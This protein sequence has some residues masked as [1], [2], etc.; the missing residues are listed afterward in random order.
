M[1][2]YSNYLVADM[3]QKLGVLRLVPA[4]VAATPLLCGVMKYR[5]TGMVAAGRFTLNLFNSKG[6][7]QQVSSQ[8][9]VNAKM[10]YCRVWHLISRDVLYTA[11]GILACARPFRVSKERRLSCSLFGRNVRLCLC[12]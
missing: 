5:R 1:A 8:F 11:A 9:V 3:S 12:H 7:P 2:A 10:K 4:F 6:R